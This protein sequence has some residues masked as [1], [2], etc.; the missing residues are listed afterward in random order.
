MRKLL[1]TGLGTGY[2]PIA[3]GTWASAGACGLFALLLWAVGPN[4]W[5]LSGAMAGLALAASAGC[6]AWGKLLPGWF[7][8]KDPPQCTLDEWAGQAVAFLFLPLGVG[9]AQHGL[10]IGAALLAFR[11]FDILKPPPARRAERL[12]AG[13]GVVADDLIAGLYA[14]LLVQIVLRVMLG[15]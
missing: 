12:P 11:G 1:L 8:K 9:W 7:G 10:A 5:I 6:A 3:P 4:D 13:I 14:N 15:L 2:L